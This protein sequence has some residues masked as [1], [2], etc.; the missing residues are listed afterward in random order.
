[1]K[2]PAPLR[3]EYLHDLV[4]ERIHDKGLR[5]NISRATTTSLEKR[6]T[7]VSDYSNWEDMRALAH[8]IKRHVIEHLPG[9][10]SMFERKATAAGAVVHYAAD[11]EQARSII[12]DL[13]RSVNAQL[14][15]KSKSMTTEEIGLNHALEQAG[16]RTVETDLGEYIVQLAGEIPSHITAP[17]LH[18]NRADIGRLFSEKLGIPYS[19]DPELLTRVAR[20]TLRADFLAA[21]VGITGVNFAIADSGSI[22]IV[23]NEG[24]ARLCSALPRIHIA[25][26]GMEKLLPDMDSLPLFLNLLGRSATGQRLT[27][28]TSLLTGPA[29]DDE[30][31]GPEQL[32]I[33]ILDNGRSRM[34]AD[35]QLREALYCIRCGACMNVCPVYQKIGGHGYGSIYPGPIGSVISPVFHGEKSA[36]HMPFTSSLCGACSEI[37]PVGID[38]HQQLLWWRKRIIGQVGG[39]WLQT[40]MMKV[41]RLVAGNTALF[42]LAGRVARLL[43]PL[44]TDERGCTRVP[45]WSKT[46]DFPALPKQS[47]KQ[48]WKE[49][50]NERS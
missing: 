42:D 46:R 49:R 48:L 33:V 45:G 24:N 23:E 1:V 11:A 18:K 20:E 28:Y 26:M 5:N 44:L 35:D 15:V 25:V 7:V 40:S 36:R 43:S 6:A 14:V 38:L 41:F 16:V 21:D 9:Y 13:A 34:A 29:K 17:A 10:L 39:G 3:P 50:D 2:S 8:D 4:A 19:E 12:R 30:S 31:D 47:F 22:V 27:C 37:C 32:H